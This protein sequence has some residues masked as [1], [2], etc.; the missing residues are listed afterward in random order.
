LPIALNLENFHQGNKVFPSEI[1]GNSGEPLPDF[2]KTQIEMYTDKIPHRHKNA[3]NS[4]TTL[5]NKNIPCYSVWVTPDGVKHKIDYF[6]SRQFYCTYYERAVLKDQAYLDL[7]YK[8]AQG[9]NLRICGFDAYPIPTN[10]SIEDCY[11]DITQPFGH[12]L[13]LYTMLTEPSSNWPW[14]KYQTFLF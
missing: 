7:L 11:K 5:K 10:T 9:I 13:V 3:V 1:D 14:K 12:E 2:F 8:R 6:T 4:G